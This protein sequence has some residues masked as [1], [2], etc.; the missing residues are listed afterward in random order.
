M[1]EPGPPPAAAVGRDRDGGRLMGDRGRLEPEPDRGDVPMSDSNHDG[2]Y[3][4]GRCADGSCRHDE[5]HLHGFACGPE[6][7]CDGIGAETAPLTE[8]DPGECDWGYCS[9]ESVALRRCGCDEPMFADD[10]TWLAVCSWHAGWDD[11]EEAE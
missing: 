2:E 3:P 4:V 6:C 9:R 8:D 10:E 7:E 5:P 11:R 1:K